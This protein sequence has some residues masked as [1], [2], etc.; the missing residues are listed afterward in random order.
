M[1]T[2]CCVINMIVVINNYTLMILLIVGL[3]ISILSNIVHLVILTK[4]YKKGTKRRLNY[5]GYTYNMVYI[6]RM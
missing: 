5:D 2:C 4:V 3:N 6:D 1:L